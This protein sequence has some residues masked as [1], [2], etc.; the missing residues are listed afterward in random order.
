MARP[1][2]FI[3]TAIVLS[4]ILRGPL[5]ESNVTRNWYRKHIRTIIHVNFVNIIRHYYHPQEKQSINVNTLLLSL[6]SYPDPPRRKCSQ[7]KH[8]YTVSDKHLRHGGSGYETILSQQIVRSDEGQKVCD[9]DH[10]KNKALP[11]F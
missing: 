11:A 7:Y 5:E 1:E 2:W 6:V 10:R 4:D 3:N 9:H 8:V